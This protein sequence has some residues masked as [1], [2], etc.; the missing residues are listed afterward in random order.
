MGPRGP[1]PADLLTAIR[2][3][4]LDKL[5]ED[6][7]LLP[8][9]IQHK[10]TH[11]ESMGSIQTVEL[12]PD[13][14]FSKAADV[15]FHEDCH[16]LW[17]SKKDMASVQKEFAIPDL[18][19]LPLTELYEGM[20]TAL[21][22]GWFATEAFGHAA[23]YW[24]SDKMIDSY[25][26]AVFP[27]YASYL[28]EGRPMDSEFAR[29]AT[30]IY[31]KKFPDA[32]RDIS[33]TSDYLVLSERIP[34]LKKF[35]DDLNKSLPRLRESNICS[36]IDSVESIKVLGESTAEHA[37]VLVAPASLA[38]LSALGLSSTQIDSVRSDMAKA[39]TLKV[40][41]KEMLFCIA[42]TP[43]RQQELLFAVLK[44]SKWP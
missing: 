35:K 39:V 7:V 24:Y 2:R 28:K 37:A 32:A 43:E 8:L 31:F 29:Q 30:M 5:G 42:D 41:K 27:L 4:E 9:P 14:K 38:K 23:K 20:A 6:T 11:G 21:G 36:P 40:G 15:V 10:S 25:S 26:H 1:W 18:G 17:F 22:Q 44:K 13:S 3:N 12:L 34:D 19:T 16:A 33:L